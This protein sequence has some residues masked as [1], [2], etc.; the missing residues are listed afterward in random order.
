MSERS[1]RKPLWFLPLS[2]DAEVSKQ[3]LL[4]AHRVLLY[5]GYKCKKMNGAFLTYRRGTR[6]K[7]ELPFRNGIPEEVM[8]HIRKVKPK[9][10][11]Q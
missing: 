3:M 8:Q 11:R 6:R 10:Y 2:P 1:K 5:A 9:G 4:T 7:I